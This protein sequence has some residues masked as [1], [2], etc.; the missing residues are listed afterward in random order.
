MNSQQAFGVAITMVVFLAGADLLPASQQAI[1]PRGGV[2][3]AANTLKGIASVKGKWEGKTDT[4][5]V[6]VEIV[7]ESMSIA[8]FLHDNKFVIF[9]GGMK[10]KIDT[11]KNSLVI[12][13]DFLSPPRATGGITVSPDGI[14]KLDVSDMKT[15]DINVRLRV[16]SFKCELKRAEEKTQ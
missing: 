15:P 5:I 9:N 16:N 3:L 7:D 6:K 8:L 2:L 10:Y 4:Y 13:D 1:A 11:K 12:A 14:V